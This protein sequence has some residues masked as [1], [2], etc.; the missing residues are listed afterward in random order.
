MKRKKEEKKEKKNSSRNYQ[1][2]FL[3]LLE[4]ALRKAGSVTQREFDRISEG[5]QQRLES[6]YG[7]ERLEDFSKRVKVNWKEVIHKLNEAGSKI[8]M[9]ESFR[10][11]KQASARVL[12][13]LAAGLKRAAENLEASLS[14]KITY[15]SGQIVDKGVYFCVVCRKIQEVK[16]RRKLP[17]CPECGNY[18]FRQA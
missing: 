2:D 15:H 4:A 3:I 16:K 12:E 10:K 6:R 11:T 8:E 14:D 1:D 13:N 18:E 5:V 9:T 17:N 7:K